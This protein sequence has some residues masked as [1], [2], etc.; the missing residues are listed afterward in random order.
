ML[1]STLFA[2]AAVGKAGAKSVNNNI[3]LISCLSNLMELMGK[4]N[5]RK[6]LGRPHGEHSLF[7]RV[8]GTQ[9]HRSSFPQI[10]ATFSA[11]ALPKQATCDDTKFQRLS[12][13]CSGGCFACMQSLA[14]RLNS[15]PLMGSF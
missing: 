7:L 15:F 4:R 14:S 3:R 11:V 9:P 1:K 12:S 10:T 2:K 13:G 6:L 8:T 5:L